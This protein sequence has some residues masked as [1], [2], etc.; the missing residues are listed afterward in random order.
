[1]DI[2]DLEA[3]LAQA[4]ARYEKATKALAPKHKGGEWE[5]WRAAYHELLEDERAL[6]LAKGEET[7]LP[8]PW[9]VPW[10]M[11]APLPHVLSSGYKT[12]LMYL[13]RE[14]DPNWDGTYVTVV[15]PTSPEV[16]PIALVEFI[17]CYDF[18]FGGPND[19]VMEGHPLHGKGLG[20]YDAHLIANSHWLA[21]LEQINSVHIFYNP[22][23]WKGPKLKHYMLLF[24]DE[25][26]ECIA[27]D[28][29]IEVFQGTFELVFEVATRR[30]FERS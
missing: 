28:H 23:A 29:K 17:R 26:F 7:A 18:K 12:Y 3:R 15:D 30:L 16:L 8:C 11:G 19:E 22:S 24:H 2:S 6:A 13:V 10:D 1:V 14:P 4:Q 20:S 9:E 25:M 21:E 5:E 27:E